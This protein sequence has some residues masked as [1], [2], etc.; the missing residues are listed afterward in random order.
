[1]PP[2][3]CSHAHAHLCVR[4]VFEV[5]AFLRLVHSIRSDD[6]SAP[7]RLSAS[8]RR[9]RRRI[10][11]QEKTQALERERMHVVPVRLAQLQLSMCMIAVVPMVA[12]LF[13][14]SVGSALARTL[15]WIF[16][17]VLALMFIVAVQPVL[18]AYG[19]DRVALD[20]QLANFTV[21]AAECTNPADKERMRR[22]ISRWYAGRG[23]FVEGG[24]DGI[25]EFEMEVHT[26]LREYVSRALGPPRFSRLPYRL[27]L[28]PRV[29]YLMTG[30][31]EVAARAGIPAA[32]FGGTQA[33]VLALAAQ[34]VY[35]TCQAHCVF[36]FFFQVASYLSSVIPV[37]PTKWRERLA[38]VTSALVAALVSIPISAMN[39]VIFFGFNGSHVAGKDKDV[40]APVCR[41]AI[42]VAISCT[43]FV[44]S[45]PT[46]AREAL[47]ALCHAITSCHMITRARK[48]QGTYSVALSPDGA[49]STNHTGHGASAV[50]QAT[51]GAG[52]DADVHTLTE[53]Y[54]SR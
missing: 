12:H 23:S 52:A 44:A 36:P 53:T 11:D 39:H 51:S 21:E 33:K 10:S 34:V 15:I 49:S 2:S 24:A 30:L 40:W 32:F 50:R 31:D 4:C 27:T 38:V 25:S 37:Q 48:A 3:S 43:L 19:R 1:L 42:V 18:R 45:F 29:C 35:A 14:G 8:W 13:A 20:N 17:C 5:A 6:G 28:L 26:T 54:S 41:A 22:L 16:L 7:A 9:S 46:E 47:S